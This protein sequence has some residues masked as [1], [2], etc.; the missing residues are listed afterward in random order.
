[1]TDEE[2]KFEIIRISVEGKRKLVGYWYL[3][4]GP[5]EIQ[6]GM[7]VIEDTEMTDTEG[8]QKIWEAFKAELT[9]PATDDMKE[10]LATAIKELV[11]Q[12][13]YDNCDWQVPDEQMIMDVEQVMLVV[14]QL[15][16]L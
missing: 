16:A 14:N 4:S 15:E 3:E 13:Q 7:N 11:S 10:A 2:P 1:M 6:H 9:Q 12:L 5:C 8:A